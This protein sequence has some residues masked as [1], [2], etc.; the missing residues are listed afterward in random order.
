M[1]HVFNL[2]IDNC[3]S[4]IK[5]RDA[6]LEDNFDKFLIDENKL[7]I[8]SNSSRAIILKKIS[9]L[10]EKKSF[11]NL[12]WLLAITLF[13]S[14]INYFYI[15]IDYIYLMVYLLLVFKIFKRALI[16]LYKQ[17]KINEQF[18]MVIASF[19]AIFL[20]EYVEAISILWL[21][22]LGTIIEEYAIYRS[23]K[24]L[25]LFDAL[26]KQK[27]KI[28]KDDKIL[29]ID[30]K[31]VKKGDKILISKNQIFLF[32]CIL[33]S[34]EAYI[35]KSSLNGESKEVLVKK[36]NSIASGSLLSSSS[37]L[38]IS[39]MEPENSSLSFLV[40]RL[41]E[42]A[43]KESNRSSLISKY[44]GYYTP[45]VLLLFSLYL[46]IT[47]LINPSNYA[48]FLYNSLIFLV[49]ACPC[50]IIIS[51][52]IAYFSTLSSLAKKGVL[53]KNSSLLDELLKVKN[54][55]LDKSGT[56]S[57]GFIQI[58]DVKM[59]NGFD[60]DYVLNLATS[61]QKYSDHPISKAFALLNYKKEYKVEDFKEEL[62]QGISCLCDNKKI[63]IGKKEFIN[64][65]FDADLYI[66]ID[67]KEAAL[68]FLDDKLKDGAKEVTSYLNHYYKLS[69]LSGDKEERVKSVAKY[70]NI[71]EYYGNLSSYDKE[72]LIKKEDY[73]FTGDGLND[74]LSLKN[75]KIGIAMNNQS[76]DISKEQADI[77]LSDNSLYSLKFLIKKA[78][79]LRRTV[80]FTILLIL[81]IKSTLLLL[82][83]F[84]LSSISLA[85][86]SDLGLLILSTLICFRLIKNKRSSS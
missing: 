4:C 72:E 77:I 59:L 11:F 86:A 75:A 54:F 63:R 57:S 64:S 16:I 50:S 69:I 70:L 43:G 36:G 49:I 31:E 14:L 13:M 5:S 82:A 51:I 24:N 42:S 45:I 61:A 74:A 71:D 46:L 21:Y 22:N 7:I 73:I 81:G 30:V 15:K 27:V 17:K 56:L 6:Y 23:K 44:A 84:N 41:K 78:K 12:N 32:D 35:D 18:L 68:L 62:S 76:N 29:P 66:E 40:K 1:K 3:P 25:N 10:V 20:S 26:Y 47:T 2:K 8:Y 85:I 38:V 79:S 9:H 48:T 58:I 55:A 19:A 67:N 39:Q 53:L 60:K 34:D 52:P 65:S 83:I 37:A 80:N 28:V 33:D